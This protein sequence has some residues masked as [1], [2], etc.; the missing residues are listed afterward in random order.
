MNTFFISGFLI[1]VLGLILS[2]SIV[3]EFL[4]VKHC[5]IFGALFT[6]K[7]LI[8]NFLSNDEGSEESK[9]EKPKEDLLVPA[10]AEPV[11]HS[12]QLLLVILGMWILIFLYS[13][14]V[15]YI[16][17]CYWWEMIMHY[18]LAMVAFYLWHYQAHRT[19]PWIPFN[20]RCKQLHM[21]HHWEVYPPQSFFGKKDESKLEITHDSFLTQHEALLYVLLF[22]FLLGA[23]LAGEK[24]IA[25]LFAF[26]FDIIVGYVGNALHQSFH[27]KG[28]WLERFHFYHELRSV[29]YIHH[30]GSTNFNY[31]VFNIGIDWI[32]GSLV[33]TNPKDSKASE[34]VNEKLSSNVGG[35]FTMALGMQAVPRSV[36]S[37]WAVNRGVV[38]CLFRILVLYTVFLL[39]NV[40][41]DNASRK[42]QIENNV[43][44]HYDLGIYLVP[45][46]SKPDTLLI[47][48]GVTTD[49][50]SILIGL[51]A[52]LGPSIRPFISVLYAFVIRQG[53]MLLGSQESPIGSLWQSPKGYVSLLTHYDSNAQSISGCI[54]VIL[55][56]IIELLRILPQSYKKY[57]LSIG[58]M[59]MLFLFNNIYALLA[60]RTIW[61]LNIV[62][63]III[64][65]YASL[66]AYEHSEVIEGL[67]P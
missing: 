5:I 45:V 59:L 6:V 33:L 46:A 56:S 15:S 8:A 14:L 18:G 1:S 2:Q 54:I 48:L 34:R 50:L 28:H 38:S 27:V 41:E 25:I 64:S 57:N 30:L 58:V 52:A 35:L 65:R 23:Y 47:S 53:I 61:S 32:L 19:L 26:I 60:L 7:L 49:I 11:Q 29:H 39:W 40:S 16:T 31:A 62:L 63:G 22:L 9:K 55:I 3:F 13:L 42:N 44:K 36:N 4:T 24:P 66:V 21:Q 10:G 43:S 20:T 17:G 12:S 51:C 37:G 67:L